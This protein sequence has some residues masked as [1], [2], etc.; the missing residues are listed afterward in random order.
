MQP[1]LGRLMP[2]TKGSMPGG[3][4]CW[5]AGEWAAAVLE[6]GRETAGW[7]LAWSV[8]SDVG[9]VAFLLLFAYFL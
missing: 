5:E 7:S 1:E 2:A 4:L 8:T 9:C 3:M 6:G